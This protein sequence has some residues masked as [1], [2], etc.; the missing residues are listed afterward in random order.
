MEIELGQKFGPTLNR[1]MVQPASFL[2]EKVPTEA[3]I[4][5]SE[6]GVERKATKLKILRLQE[7]LRQCHYDTEIF[8]NEIRKK[9]QKYNLLLEDFKKLGLENEKMKKGTKERAN[10]PQKKAKTE[11][12]KKVQDLQK[13][14]EPFERQVHQTK[15]E[16]S[17]ASN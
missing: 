14:V 7:D 9:D 4:L 6:I 12:D 11:E 13:E 10:N 15:K 2:P 3:E 8:K 5:R 17:K 16:V 1:C